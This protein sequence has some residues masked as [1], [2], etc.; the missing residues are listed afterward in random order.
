[1]IESNLPTRLAQALERKRT[2][3]RTNSGHEDAKWSGINEEQAR[4]APLHRA[5]V[6]AVEVLEYYKQFSRLPESVQLKERIGGGKAD[7]AL[8]ALEA[9]IKESGNG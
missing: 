8:A 6:H 3:M 7:T 5:L 1:M 9:A 2:G 4:L